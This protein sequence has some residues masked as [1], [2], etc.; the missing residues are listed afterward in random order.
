MVGAGVSTHLTE[1]VPFSRSRGW[2]PSH[3]RWLSCS[4]VTAPEFLDDS[5]SLGEITKKSAR[6]ELRLSE[7]ATLHYVLAEAPVPDLKP[8][9]VVQTEAVRLKLGCASVP[10]AAFDPVDAGT[11]TVS[12]PLRSAVG[13]IG[14]VALGALAPLNPATA[15]VVAVVASDFSLDVNV[16]SEVTELEFTTSGA[17]L[18]LVLRCAPPPRCLRCQ[19]HHR[20]P[21]V[22]SPS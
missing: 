1:P 10:A 7:A 3:G 6:V 11:V 13:T 20:A 15:Y 14:F 4:D 2:V 17:S 8:C 19:T 21:C 12:T 5:P 16:Q 9:D 22:P 18:A